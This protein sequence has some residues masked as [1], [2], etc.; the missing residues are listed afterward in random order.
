MQPKKSFWTPPS[1]P[2]QVS[3]ALQL[4]FGCVVRL[5]LALFREPALFF[6]LS[7]ATVVLSIDWGLYRLQ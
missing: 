3:D 6:F 4:M 2:R 1:L 7:L 5:I